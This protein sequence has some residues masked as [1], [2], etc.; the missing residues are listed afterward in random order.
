[1]FWVLEFCSS[2]CEYT[3][4]RHCNTISSP[5][6]SLVHLLNTE[7]GCK[8][9]HRFEVSTRLKGFDLKMP[10]GPLPPPLL[11]TIL[12]NFSPAPKRSYRVFPRKS[13]NRW[14]MSDTSRWTGCV[15]YVL[16]QEHLWFPQSVWDVNS[17][18]YVE[19][20]NINV[21]NNHKWGQRQS[22]SRWS[23]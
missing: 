17:Q 10:T 9:Q 13:L 3:Q 16:N 12:K 15:S 4:G 2:F 23:W 6:A 21:F 19:V 22:L 14:Q 8:H 1:M 7:S 20:C 11:P 18:K 5:W